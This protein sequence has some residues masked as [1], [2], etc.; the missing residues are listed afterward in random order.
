MKRR[1][2][3]RFRADARREANGW[4]YEKQVARLKRALSSADDVPAVLARAET[5]YRPYSRWL[6]RGASRWAAWEGCV[7]ALE[8]LHQYRAAKRLPCSDYS[9]E[10]IAAIAERHLPVLEWMDRRGLLKKE[11]CCNAWAL[12][13]ST[14]NDD[15][16]ALEWLDARG[17]LDASES[18]KML[19]WTG[20]DYETEKKVV[21]W[22]IR[23]KTVSYADLEPHLES[24]A[25]FCD[26]FVLDWLH[27]NAP[28]KGA[29]RMCG[30]ILV[31]GF[32]GKYPEALMDWID[33]RAS[34]EAVVA[35]TPL[36]SLWQVCAAPEYQ[37]FHERFPSPAVRSRMLLAVQSNTCWLWGRDMEARRLLFSRENCLACNGRAIHAGARR[38][39]AGGR[40][41]LRRLAKSCRLSPSDFAS[42]GLRWTF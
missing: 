6:C 7:P 27:Q 23:N 18:L 37:L 14:E 1:A 35:V 15:F 12:S 16:R 4:F 41:K 33:S 28:E 30:E 8:W 31:N 32:G 24:A 40:S 19:L 5:A 34:M 26:V 29:V 42:V 11:A 17:V 2:R 3:R 9:H 20:A 21:R 25:H 13:E 39:S 22:M 10:T 36:L 38:R